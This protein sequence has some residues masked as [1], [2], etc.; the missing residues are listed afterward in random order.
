MSV[1]PRHVLTLVDFL[2]TSGG[3]EKL[4]LA[5]V[6]R[7]D[8]ER[9]RRTYAV[10]R[11]GAYDSEA[12]NVRAVMEQL[13]AAGVEFLGLDR[14]R[15]R[16]HTFALHE[17][18]PLASYLRSQRVDVVHGHKFGSNFWGAIWGRAARVPVVVAHEHSWAFQ[19]Q[20]LRRLI[21][22]ELI[23]RAS[24]AVIAV[25]EADRRRMV[26][27]EGIPAEKIR[28]IPN[29]IVAMP[30]GDAGRVRAELAIAPDAPVLIWVGVIRPEKRVDL[31]IGAT[32]RLRERFPGLHTLV[33]GPGL[34]PRERD[35]MVRLAA[36]LGVGDVVH[37]LG[38]RQDVSD[39]LAA[40]DVAVLPS[41]RE[42]TPLAILEY[43]DAGKPIVATGVGGVP[44]LIQD[45][46]E[47]LLIEPR[48]LEALVEAVASLL[49][50]PDRAR[51]LG[52][53][54]RERSQRDFRFDATVA[55]V[56][57][58]YDE[59]LARRGLAAPADPRFAEGVG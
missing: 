56:E 4:A 58:L 2:G 23:A 21:D 49:A 36:E 54:A 33:P 5:L 50:D 9:Y 17:W 51:R 48:D 44:D 41:D 39:L 28:M 59:L 6:L 46:E 32:Q 42:G 40:A 1:P 57:Q 25:S 15:T 31:V 7:L 22:R 30:P 43:M 20:A 55:Q 14:G 10:S 47:G 29:G 37:V 35:A 27:V 19:G 38:P 18:R 13:D 11:W 26:E 45:G 16:R 24:D 53:R 34:P 8:P 3:A 12:A 52:G